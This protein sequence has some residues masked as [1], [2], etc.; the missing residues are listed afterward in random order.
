M[1]K[2]TTYNVYNNIHKT[3]QCEWNGKKQ[4]RRDLKHDNMRF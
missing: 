3:L 2:E 1:E 4:S